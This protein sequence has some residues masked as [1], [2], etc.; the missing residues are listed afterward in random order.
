MMKCTNCGAEVKEGM[1]FCTHCGSPLEDVPQTT[2]KVEQQRNESGKEPKEY[3]EEP[4]NNPSEF[5]TCPNCGK[6]ID[7]KL[8]YCTFCGTKL[9]EDEQEE[10]YLGGL[11]SANLIKGSFAGFSIFVTNKRIIG[12]SNRSNVIAGTVIGAAAG[13]ITGVTIGAGI[14][15]KVG[16]KLSN[17]TVF[18]PLEEI[19]NKSDFQIYGNEISRVE[20]TPPYYANGGSL[21]F[22]RKKGDI[23]GIN[24][25]NDGYREFETLKGLLA[26]FLQSK[27]ILVSPGATLPQGKFFIVQNPHSVS[28]VKRGISKGALY[29]LMVLGLLPVLGAFF[30]G[31]DLIEEGIIFWKEI[32]AVIGGFVIFMIGFVIF[33]Y[34]FKRNKRLL[35]RVFLVLLSI[36]AILA[37][38]SVFGYI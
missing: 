34:A 24:I 4:V 21:V 11:T 18:P 14:G 20:L 12:V 38:L 6:S 33:Y 28:G 2:P 13:Q 32:Y 26:S 31:I 15:Y 22:Y 7:K 1:K 16:G 3:K 8:E 29:T 9:R 37:T 35:K 25:S 27:P 19:T 30:A 17:K 5:I 23:L 36:A 10:H